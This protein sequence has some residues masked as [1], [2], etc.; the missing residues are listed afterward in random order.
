[1]EYEDELERMRNRRRRQRAQ[2]QT[3]SNANTVHND[4]DHGNGRI[5]GSTGTRRRQKTYSDA[6]YDDSY[7]YGRHRSRRMGV[8]PDED[9]EDYEAY[10]DYDGYDEDG[11]YD[12]YEERESRSVGRG[13]INRRERSGPRGGS[14]VSGRRREPGGQDRYSRERGPM[15]RSGPGRDTEGKSSKAPRKKKKRFSFFKLLLLLVLVAGGLFA[16]LYTRTGSGYWTIAVFGVDSRDGKLE[17]GALSDVEMICVID[18]GTGDIKLV[19][20]FR[21]TYLEIN[22]D[23]TYHKI[24]EAYFKGGHQ[25]AVQALERNLDLSIDDYATFNW[26]AVVDAINILGGIDLEI[27]DSEFKYINSFITETVESTGIGSHHLESAGMNHLDGVQAVAYARLRL[28]DTDYNR[29]ARQRLVIQLAMNKA[30]EA[31]LKTLSN[32]VKA[33]LPQLSTSIGV[34]DLLPMARNIRKYHITET[35]GFPFSRGETHIGKKDCVIPLTLES[36]VVQLHQFLY[37]IE[38]FQPSQTVKQISAK[39]A[40]DSGMGE[41]AENAPEAKIL[42]QKALEGGGGGSSN[43]GGSGG[44]TQKDPA[45]GNSENQGGISPPADTA[46]A[47]PEGT[48]GQETE[49]SEISQEASTEDMSGEQGS[50]EEE[51]GESSDRETEPS[52]EAGSSPEETSQANEPGPVNPGET[53]PEIGPGM[54]EAPSSEPETVLREP[55]ETTTEAGPGVQ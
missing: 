27:S 49:T 45:P 10:E 54:T 19:S 9:Y 41:V 28:M 30:K 8:D 22:P 36:N 51:N 25:Q 11:G 26:K 44:Q 43:A 46:P 39:V 23:G 47:M 13:G 55:E 4:F 21:D 15:A 20:V 42:G 53:E 5:S 29:T 16:F 38:N 35:G 50:L 12:Q 1:M 37:G 48:L 32:L 3:G 24:N 2:Q 17:K 40:S 6:Y 31:D 34:D 52:N 18:R 14:S 7:E 33:I